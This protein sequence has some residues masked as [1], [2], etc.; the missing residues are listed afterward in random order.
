MKKQ[1]KIITLIFSSLIILALIPC[2]FPQI[3][4]LAVLFVEKLKHDDIH[5]SFWMKQMFA[6]AACAIFTILV[7]NAVLFTQKGRKIFE[8]NIA[9]F[10]KI[11]A[12]IKDNK[13]Y[14]FTIF[15]LYLFGYIT[16]FRANFWNK[17][18]DDLA[19][20]IE[21]SRDWMNWYRYIS[22]IGSIFLHT[23]KQL[24]DIAPLTQLIATFF[25]ALASFFIIHIFNKRFTYFSCIASL[26]VG[27]F[28]YFLSN[29]SYRYDS[30]YMGLAVL[31]S[32]IPFLFIEDKTTFITTSV[33][34]L[35]FMCTSYQSASGIYIF[36][37]VLCVFKM[38]TQDKKPVQ[39][40]LKTT[41]IC[42][43]CYGLTLFVFSKLFIPKPDYEVYADE[44]INI[45]CLVP[46]AITYIKNLLAHLS[47]TPIFYFSMLV[48]VIFIVHSFI[49]T[50]INC[51][52][53]S[54]LSILVLVIAL[55][56]TFGSYLAL[57][58]PLYSARAFIGIGVF[59]GCLC[60]IL[61]DS[62]SSKSKKIL[63]LSK[64][65]TFCLSW[66]LIAFSFAYGN[67]QA[68]Q[69][70]Y[71]QFRTT[72]LLKDLSEVVADTDKDVELLFAGDIGHSRTVKNLIEVYPVAEE[73][74]D[75][76]LTPHRPSEF[77]LQSYNF[78]E[79][80]AGTNNDFRKADFPVLIDNQYNKIQ[81]EN[82]RYLI[83]FK[84]P[85]FKVIR[86][87]NIEG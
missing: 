10:K 37:S 46:N 84:N 77:I 25:I 24:I 34:C 42:V 3:Q 33:L 39:E 43:L 8:H 9:S 49:N 20:Q 55:P 87:R 35:F 14:L 26:P 31:V 38:W 62:E 27:L 73:L 65:A 64:I 16:I 44:A 85:H 68:D 47:G 6:F 78:C 21:G 15:L 12:L 74:I 7:I 59:I 69:K 1:N 54:F 51:L 75:I 13:K 11:F 18:I 2:L 29:L 52:F 63:N 82:N 56:F 72:L 41:L 58:K 50:N 80:K 30:P 4:H 57:E 36:M 53:S 45:S 81:G 32:I 19:R 23:S 70:D 40:I 79:L 5:D 86:T 76:G 22:E 28:P 60:L 17:A 83:T 67:A 71:I 61:L 48:F 66:C